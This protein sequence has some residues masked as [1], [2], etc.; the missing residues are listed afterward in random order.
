MREFVHLHVTSS[1]SFLW[2]TFTPEALVK[3]TLQLR[4]PY[5]A[6]TDKNTLLGITRFY[7][8]AREYGITPIIGAEVE[9]NNA[10]WM[11]FLVKNIQGYRN[12]CRIISHKNSRGRV[13]LEN[14]YA[15]NK[16][17]ICLTGGRG[18]F[19]RRLIEN[20]RMDIASGHI[21]K[22]KSIFSSKRLYLAIQ[23]HKI[24]GDNEIIEKYCEIAEKLH[25]PTV[26]TFQVAYLHREDYE[27]H[28]VLCNVAV[29]YHH[30]ELSPLPGD[31]FF[32][33]DKNYVEEE[34]SEYKRSIENTYNIANMCKDFSLPLKRMRPPRVFLS[35]EESY[36][37][38]SSIAL[39][40][41]ATKKRPV[42]LEYLRRFTS[43]LDII[44]KQKLSDFFLIVKEIHDFAKKKNIRC[45]IRG[46]AASSLIVYLLLSG[47]D[48]VE[49]NLL[50]E[51]FL[52][53]GRGDFPDVDID[54][55]SDRRDE[56]FKFIF[57]KYHKKCALI[58]TILTFRV[59]GAVRMIG[60][61][62][63]YPYKEIKR[64]NKSLPSAMRRIDIA[65]ALDRY[66]E[67]EN[68]PILRE[69]KL[70]DLV[71]RVSGL[72]YARSV[73]LGGLI[74]SD[75]DIE[76]IISLDISSKGY[77]VLHLDKEDVDKWGLFKLDILGLRMHTAIRKSLEILE[78]QRINLDLDNIPLD[79]PL[80]YKTLCRG[81]TLGIFQLESPGQRELVRRLRPKKFFDLI[82]EISLFRPGP[83]RGNMVYDFI[84]RRHGREEPF[85]PS[86]ELIPILKDTHGVIV[87]QEQVLEIAH[88]FAGMDYGE[89]DAFRRAMTKDRSKKEMEKLKQK[90][91][92]GAIS[93]GHD[94]S[95]A[96]AVFDM[97]ACFAAYGF[98]KAHAASFSHITYQSAYLKTHYPREFYLGLLNAGHVGSYP[99]S[100]ILNEAKRKG[101]PLY[102][103]HVNFSST[104]FL[105]YKSGII[106]PLTTIKFVGETL[107]RR[108]V[109]E[110]EKRGPFKNDVDLKTR[111]NLPER[112]VQMVKLAGAVK[113]TNFNSLPN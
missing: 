56:V 43:E 2:G 28:K 106:F 61:A 49:N 98:C 90:F 104:E 96:E 14:I 84:N 74:I 101:I 52:N 83:V 80:T 27:V 18:S 91:V 95:V 26:V 105:P 19:F 25:I 30:R 12:L 86:K 64:L 77:P 66:P 57:E 39:K 54:F 35:S 41:L 99:P 58:S 5:V 21:L 103:P 37:K 72:P 55:D 50:F 78:T 11:V 10:G 92:E 75:E 59:R 85:Y 44:K 82:V 29:K 113:I 67:L 112:V 32:L 31:H 81:D 65:S 51:R 7:V 71:K 69:H 93:N 76:N 6:L 109:K 36:K 46:S 17:L 48:P 68:H 108:I 97:V 102:P 1:F 107:A 45:S 53:E 16:G 4:F 13:E 38:L 63:D 73:H 88:H 42:S 70:L 23:N 94:E 110:R 87:F 20:N 24:K 9:I 100:V 62:L 47:I 89:A 111:C 79:D 60:R 40:S 8:C 22:L 3:K 34:F 15:L 33:V